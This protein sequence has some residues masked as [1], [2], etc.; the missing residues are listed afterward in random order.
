MIFATGACGAVT[1]TAERPATPV[2]CLVRIVIDVQ[3]IGGKTITIIR[4]A[5]SAISKETV[6]MAINGAIG[7]PTAPLAPTW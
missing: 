7:I 5:Q 6:K 3:S 4:A 2:R 1:T